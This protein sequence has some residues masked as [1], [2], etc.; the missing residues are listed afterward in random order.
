MINTLILAASILSFDPFLMLKPMPDEDRAIYIQL[1]EKST[2]SAIHYIDVRFLET[3][4]FSGLACS[5]SRVLINK[6]R[7][8]LSTDERKEALMMHEFGHTY[9]LRHDATL[10]R[11]LER[12]AVTTSSQ[13]ATHS[14]IPMSIMTNEDRITSK[15]WRTFKR[16]YFAE[17]R[18]KLKY[19]RDPTLVSS[20]SMICDRY[21]YED[22]TK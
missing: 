9:G 3:S 17:L 8:D 1:W 16:Y 22:L 12:D 10:V 4:K 13:E 19:H 2:G 21:I 15:D 11:V 7:W 18:L 20:S 14:Y 6:T 5:S